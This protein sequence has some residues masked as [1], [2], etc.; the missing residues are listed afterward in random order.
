MMGAVRVR[1]AEGHAVMMG[2]VGVRV[3]EGHDV[4][5]G[6]RP[7]FVFVCISYVF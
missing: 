3:A 7:E 6:G 2:G 5:M 1:V 4:M